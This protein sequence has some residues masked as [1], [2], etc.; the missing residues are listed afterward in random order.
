MT[1]SLVIMSHTS[2]SNH[3]VL[4]ANN[5]NDRA[6]PGQ[7]SE[8]LSTNKIGLAGPRMTDAHQRKG[9]KAMRHSQPTR[10]V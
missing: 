2:S 8:V 7:K 10:L 6:S 4:P 3:A 9:A 1:V 5:G